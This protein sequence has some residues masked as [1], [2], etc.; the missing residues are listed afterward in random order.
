MDQL[1]FDQ[2][3]PLR[4]AQRTCELQKQ[5]VI[6]PVKTPRGDDAWLVTDYAE[7]R[8]L[9]TDDRLGQSHPRPEEASRVGESAMFGGP[10]GNFE[11]ELTDRPKFRAFLQPHFSPKHVRALRPAIEAKTTELLDRLAGLP[12]PADLVETLAELPIWVI[13]DLLGVPYDDRAQFRA[14]SEAASDTRDAARSQQGLAELYEYGHK[15]LARKRQEPGDD[16]ITRFCAHADVPDDTIAGLSMGVLFAGGETTVAAI[17]F[18]ALALLSEPGQWQSLVNDPSLV[19]AAVDEMLRMP[20]DSGGGIIRYARTDMDIGGTRIKLGDL[21]MMDVCAGNHDA[22]VFT[23]PDRVD[24]TRQGPA[25]LTFGHGAHYCVGAP[26]AKAELEILFTH[27]VRR[28]PTMRLAVGVEE[29]AVGQNL[30][31]ALVALPV[32]W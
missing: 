4:I 11:T 23:Q 29:L 20:G 18:G 17:G 30:L 14:S 13:C 25:H 7:I 5:G 12:R 9:L 26:L 8:R 27:L 22:A 3:H 21:V 28:F 32:T 16:M 10:M 15:L 6:H 2:P 19:P 1:P 31:P 24:V